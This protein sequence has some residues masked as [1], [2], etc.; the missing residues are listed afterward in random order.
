M[1]RCIPRRAAVSALLCQV[2]GKATNAALFPSRGP[3]LIP[4]TQIVCV[5]TAPADGAAPC[6]IDARSHAST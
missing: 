5:R 1:L 6:R 2:N 3:A 4:R